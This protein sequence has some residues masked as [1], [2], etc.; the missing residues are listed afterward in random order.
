MLT[1]QIVI[2]GL[3]I[4]YMSILCT[5]AVSTPQMIFTF[6]IPCTFKIQVH[7]FLTRF[8]LIVTKEAWITI[9]I[10]LTFLSNFFALT[11]RYCFICITEARITHTFVIVYA[12]FS[13]E[14]VHY[15]LEGV[16][17]TSVQLVMAKLFGVLF[18]RVAPE[19]RMAHLIESVAIF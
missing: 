9:S 13:R 12:H 8:D 2:A 17:H 3:P 7:L 4:E 14:L 15:F 11:N 6:S 10:T 16:R 19:I 18:D 5:F 1:Y